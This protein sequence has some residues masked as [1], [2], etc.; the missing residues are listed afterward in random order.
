[1]TLT[2]VV[3]RIPFKFTSSDGIA[4]VVT[5]PKWEF[6]VEE[7]Q[8][9]I[10][11][12][13]QLAGVD[14]GYDQLGVGQSI[15]QSGRIT[16]RFGWI[17]DGSQSIDFAVDAMIQAINRIGRGRLWTKT[18]PGDEYTQNRWCWARLEEM[19]TFMFN[20][21]S[22]WIKTASLVFRKMSD[23][24]AE[25]LIESAVVISASPQT[26]VIN[27]PGVTVKNAV[28]VLEGTYTNPIVTNQTNG[29]IFQSSRDGSSSN[30]WLKF[31]G[32]AQSVEFSTDGGSTYAGDFAN[33][34]MP[35]GQ[36]QLMILDPGDNNIQLQGCNGATFVYGFYPSFG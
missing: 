23:W 28:F 26:V 27:N 4:E 34:T 30:H 33:V 14:Y 15:K 25:D 7:A 8:G 24:Y 17:E 16:I 11:P 2:H 1:M 20:G 12:E 19:P 5:F 18:V 32:E 21:R 13:L 22:R 9:L 3:P 35:S 29:Y 36:V 6:E 31:G 10:V